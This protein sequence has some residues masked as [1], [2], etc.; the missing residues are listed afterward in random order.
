MTLI[1]DA[2]AVAEILLGT[3]RGAAAAALLGDHDLLAPQ[4]LTVEVAS[5]I[6]GWS[7]GGHVTEPQAL[8]AFSEFEILGIEQVAMMP[9][10]PA[11]HALRHNLTAYDAM[12]VV[13]ARAA[14][15]PLLTLDARLAKS[16]DDCT[17]LP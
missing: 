1:V 14:G 2:S 8:R 10:L 13:L 6:R 9:L 11:V 3:T 17:V 4:H 5:V 16:A 7:L 12:Y 15:C